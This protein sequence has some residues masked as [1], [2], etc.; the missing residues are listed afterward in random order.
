DRRVSVAHEDTTADLFGYDPIDQV[1]SVNYGADG[2]SV[3]YVYDK[4]GNRTSVTDNG[5][6]TPYRS[7]LLN[8]YAKVGSAPLTYDSNGNLLTADG[9]AYAY[10]A[11]NRLISATRGTTTATFAYDPRNRRVEQT[12]NGAVILFYFDE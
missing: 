9:W 1:T 4:V 10:D 3:S 2:R 12:I 7:N 5:T 8:E 11:Q 6:T